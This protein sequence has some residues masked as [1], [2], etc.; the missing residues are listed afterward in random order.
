MHLIFRDAK[1]QADVT[2][3]LSG[4]GADEVFG[5]Y[6]WYRVAQQRDGLQRKIPGL[7]QLAKI[8]P[9]VS[10][11]ATLKKVL[12]DDYLVTAN[13]FSARSVVNEFLP[14]TDATIESRK[15][16]WPSQRPGADGMFIY[17]QQTYLQPLLQRQ[18]RMSMA[19]GLEAREPFLDHKLAEWANALSPEA[20]L[21]GGARKAL[22]KSLATR[23][24]PDEIVYRKKVG[25]EMPLG[26]WLTPGGALSH[27]VEALRDTGSLAAQVTD[28]AAVSRLIDEH[29]AGK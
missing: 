20:K 8:A 1:E 22:L 5:G 10:K 29:R 16:F 14:V 17:D 24:L 7:S 6:A 18:D 4:E 11:F 27:R 23:W 25:F 9:G 2:V 28:R 3:L 12:S 15:R 13:A 26:E 21:A 19:A